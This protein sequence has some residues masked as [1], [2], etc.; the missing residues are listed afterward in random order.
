MGYTTDF[1]GIFELDKPLTSEH[2]VFLNAFANT[3][4]VKRNPEETAKRP[5]PIREA[6]G[7]PV[8]DEG[9]YFV[10]ESGFCGQDH[11]DDI[12]DYNTAPSKQ[13]GLWCHWAPSFDYD[14]VDEIHQMSPMDLEAYFKANGLPKFIAWD[15]SEKFYDYVEWLEYLIENFLKPW[16]YTLNGEVE[17]KGEDSSDLGKI[18][19]EDNKVKTLYGRIEYS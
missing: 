10:G 5:D 7:L 6:V 2:A 17:W 11:G 1:Y 15:E 8:G 13:P 3:R 14:V 19:V 16:G 18:V 9:E 12:T 4:R